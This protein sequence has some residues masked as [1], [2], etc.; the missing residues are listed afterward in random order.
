MLL[1]L[2]AISGGY[3]QIAQRQLKSLDPL[4]TS[5]YVGAIGVL[6]FF[7]FNAMAGFD[8]NILY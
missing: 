1:V 6:F 8:Y 7:P 4:T 2:A 3:G 5:F